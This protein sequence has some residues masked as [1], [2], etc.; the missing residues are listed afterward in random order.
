VTGSVTDQRKATVQIGWSA[1]ADGAG[2]AV[3]GYDLRWAV[4]AAAW[5]S[6]ITDSQFFATTGVTQDTGIASL[7]GKTPGTAQ[8]YSLTGLPPFNTWSIALRG[9]DAAGNRSEPIAVNTVNDNT[10]A[11]NPA[12][13]WNQVILNEGPNGNYF[14]YE[15]ITADFN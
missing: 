6:S 14:G 13:N 5:G 15:M 8:S 1:P 3:A 9:V 10:I 12:Q 7:A 11:G 2:A 4:P